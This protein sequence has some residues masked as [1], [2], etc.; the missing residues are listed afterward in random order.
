MTLRYYELIFFFYPNCYKKKIFLKNINLNDRKKVDIIGS[1]K[2]Q[3]F[4][5]NS[6]SVVKKLNMMVIFLKVWATDQFSK[7]K[8]ACFVN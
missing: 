3:F 1:L 5:F 4:S 2:N 7:T 6:E 8:S